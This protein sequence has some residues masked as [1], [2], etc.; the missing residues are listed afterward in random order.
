MDTMDTARRRDNRE[1]WRH[2]YVTRGSLSSVLTAFS[3]IWR[4]FDSLPEKQ[5]TRRGLMEL[6]D[7]QLKD[8]GISRSEARREGS[9]PFWD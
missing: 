1:S 8:I 2:S 3:S 9:R 6:T 5:L 4:W 7:D